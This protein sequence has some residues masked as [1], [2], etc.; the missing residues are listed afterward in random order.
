[1][2]YQA[3]YRKWRPTVFEDMVG[4]NHITET[5]KNEL[6]SN[7]LAH[8]YLFCGTRG[9]GKTTMAKI[10]S[11]AVNCEN[12]LPDGN[13]CNSCDAC[14]G[15]MNNAVMDVIE[16]DAASNNGVDNIRELRDDVL[17]TPAS[18]KYKV[19]IIDEVHMLSTGAFNALLKTLE[20]PP[21]HVLFILA[22]TEP[23]KIPATIQSR[24]QR[25]D[26]R[27]I[28]AHNIAGR[29][30][31]ITRKDN[32]QITS[33]AVRMVAELGDGSMRDALSVLDLLT[34]IK[35][36][37]TVSDI[38]NVTGL[39]GKTFLTGM[40]AALFS[41]DISKALNILNDVLVSGKETTNTAEELL[42]FLR[43]LLI[44]RFTDNPENL[45][46]K[47]EETV[48][49]LTDIANQISKE[50][51]V[52]AINLL[53]TAIYS[54]K[55]STNPRAVL[56]STFVKLC[57]PETD[58]SSDAFAARIARLENVGTVNV[59]PP[60]PVEIPKPKVTEPVVQ[61]TPVF[62]EPA[63]VPPEEKQISDS[64]KIRKKLYAQ[65]PYLSLLGDNVEFVN[66]NKTTMVV[67][68]NSADM[69]IA[70][71]PVFIKDLEDFLETKVRIT[72]KGAKD[73]K[74]VTD[75]FETLLK[76]ASQFENIEII[77]REGTQQD[78]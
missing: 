36:E 52:H 64:G 66:Q 6:V 8:A 59:A 43:E 29:I 35:G 20:E 73:E 55:T 45:L 56:E 34:G 70:N 50:S 61:E 23:H 12:P 24:C 28:S 30:S 7:K 42:A 58:S 13:P 15:I 16:I 26:F 2:A 71:N 49:S 53:S 57:F 60:K 51:I 39:I 32:I 31:E 19:Y 41:G 74:I 47:T 68:E 48:K 5:I 17:Y 10:L 4:Q 33:D 3:I 27:R 67:C 65:Y 18:V 22:T 1:M 25:F 14:T 76:N 44:C 77:E 37:I 9:T 21:A 62:T 46:D 38:E 63:P 11:R 40:T 75:P 69:A 78:G 54:M 72:Y